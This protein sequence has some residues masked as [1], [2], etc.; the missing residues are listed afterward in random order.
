MKR[1]KIFIGGH[2]LPLTVN[3]DDYESAFEIACGNP[4]NGVLLIVAMVDY[5]KTAKRVCYKCIRNYGFDIG[6]IIHVSVHEI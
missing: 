3:A 4:W 6:K 2:E 1:F 5:N